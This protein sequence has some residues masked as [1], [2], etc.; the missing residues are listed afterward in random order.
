MKTSYVLALSGIIGMC[1]AG[2]AIFATGIV[3][4]TGH[5]PHYGDAP[6][7]Q[8]NDPKI[9]DRIKNFSVVYIKIDPQGILNVRQAFFSRNE[10]PFEYID[11]QVKLLV[12]S[13]GRFYT[14]DWQTLDSAC[15]MCGPQPV[16]NKPGDYSSEDYFLRKG[17][18]GFYFGKPV[19]IYVY[20]ENNT[21]S[22]DPTWPI[23]FTQY[24]AAMRGIPNPAGWTSLDPN[25]TFYN[26]VVGNGKNNLPDS[27]Y[28]RFDNLY[29]SQNGS[30][31]LN[32]GTDQPSSGN[33]NNISL[34]SINFNL[35]MASNG[36]VVPMII[37]PDTGNGTGGPPPFSQ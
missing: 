32:D 7:I 37:D 23:M 11:D 28:L 33:Q 9:L 8:V 16:S 24:G 2:L 34:H 5:G 27:R 36:G 20:I 17:F 22:F 10:K 13:R 18:S 30:V 15:P 1:A 14:G 21:L 26:A 35:R 29:K 4:T 19:R 25:Y 3:G 31:Y 12:S 6:T